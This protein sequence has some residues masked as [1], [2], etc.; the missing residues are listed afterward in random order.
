MIKHVILWTLKAELTEEEKAKIK[1]EI[2]IGLE[3]LAGKIAGLSEIKVNINPMPSSNADLMLDSSFESEQ[4]LKDYSVHP[5]HVKVA[6]EKVR[7][8]TATRTCLDYIV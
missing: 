4:A 6:N 1:Q 5:L 2:K 8:Y 3:G 7:P